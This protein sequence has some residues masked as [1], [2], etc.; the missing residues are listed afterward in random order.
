MKQNKRKIQRL[1]ERTLKYE[2][3]YSTIS[4]LSFTTCGLDTETHTHRNIINFSFHLVSNKSIKCY[5]YYQNTNRFF[6]SDI[7]SPSFRKYFEKTTI[8]DKIISKVNKVRI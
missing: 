4:A 1:W 6:P 5:F 7:I 8:T 3:E 2:P